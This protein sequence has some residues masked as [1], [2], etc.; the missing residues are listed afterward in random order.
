MN[1]RWAWTTVLGAKTLTHA[2]ALTDDGFVVT[3][4]D[5]TTPRER[6]TALAEAFARPHLLHLADGRVR[7]EVLAAVAARLDAAAVGSPRDATRLAFWRAYDPARVRPET[8]VYAVERAGGALEPWP[9]R[10][11]GH[12]LI[13]QEYLRGSPTHLL[14][15]E[16]FAYGPPGPRAPRHVRETLRTRMLAALRPG[17]GLTAADGFPSLAHA[18]IPRRD[19]TWDRRHDGETGLST[20]PGVVT[21]GYRY[22]H[23]T[24]WTDYAPERVLSRDPRIHLFAPAEVEDELMDALAQARTASPEHH[25]PSVEA[26]AALRARA[27]DRAPWG[28]TTRLVTPAAPA[29]REHDWGT[30]AALTLYGSLRPEVALPAAPTSFDAYAHGH[31]YNARSDD[32]WVAP[33]GSGVLRAEHWFGGLPGDGVDEVWHVLPGGGRRVVFDVCTDSTQNELDL[34]LSAD[35]A[36]TLERLCAHVAALLDAYGFA[37]PEERAPVDVRRR[38]D[39]RSAP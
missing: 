17:H 18:L 9:L 11:D 21:L 36:A 6:R 16:V 33:D 38:T 8:L 27:V 31:S 37:A 20:E 39:L 23:D 2:A 14:P 26:Y 32:A 25:P 1:A 12:G 29:L 28:R 30:R 5:A 22:G 10:L 35:D 7:F 3:T 4:S 24:G 34:T 19:W 15:D 13:A